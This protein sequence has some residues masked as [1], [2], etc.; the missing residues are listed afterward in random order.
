MRISLKILIHSIYWLVFLLFSYLLS[1]NARPTDWPDFANITPHYII[2]F[3]WALIIFYLFYFYFIRFFE[4]QQFAKYLIFSIAMSIAITS[5]FL[6]VHQIYLPSYDFMNFRFFIPPVIGTFII[7]QCGSL[8]K[9][10]ENWFSDLKNK[11]EL[12]NRNLKN[13]LE[14]LKSQINPHF[15]FNSLNNIDSLIHASPKDASD[16]LITLSDMMRYVLYE[17]GT[18]KVS[19]Q[20]EIVYVKN[21]IN[22]QQLRYKDKNY[23][24]AVYPENC[25]GILIAPMMLI[26]FI[27]NA[28]KFAD[29]SFK[30]PV[31]DIQIKCNK[32][33]LLFLCTNFFGDN[34]VNKGGIGIENTKRRLELMYPEKYDINISQE[35]NIFKVELS[36]NLL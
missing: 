20:S 3:I 36:I 34:F 31:I 9:G 26:P 17:T 15:L 22:L 19:L 14:L 7:A 6:P 35:N 16:A 21:Y 28:F 33:T 8:V 24:R 11:A 2:N 30:K 18:D 5:V 32:N 4:K 25:S 29:N 10:F 23:I 12:E 13:E 27:E 1:N